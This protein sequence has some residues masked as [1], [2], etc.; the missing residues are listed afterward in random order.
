METLVPI[1]NSIPSELIIVDTGGT[2][3]SIE[4]AREYADLVVPFTWCNDFA[5]ARNTGLEKAKGEWFLY[6]DD[7]EWFEDAGEIIDF[8][9]SGEYLNYNSATYPVRNYQDKEGKRWSES[10]CYRMVKITKNTRFVSPI[11]EILLPTPLPQKFFSCFVHHYGYVF[12]NEEERRKHCY[13]NISLLEAVIK[14]DP[15]NQRLRMQLAQEYG[16]LKDYQ[17]SIELSKESIAIVSKQNQISEAQIIYSGWNMKNVVYT[18]ILLEKREEA[19]QLAVKYSNYRWINTVTKNNLSHVLARLAY[20]L[21]KEDNCFRYTEVYLN[22]YRKLMENETLRLEETLVDQ[23]ESYTEENHFSTLLAAMKAAENMKDRENQQKYLME[24]AKANFFTISR[25]DFSIILSI[26]FDLKD[27]NQQIS[28]MNNFM[29]KE[30]FR[31]QLLNLLEKQPEFMKEEGMLELISVCGDSKEFI[32]YKI[33][34]YYEQ[35]LGVKELVEKYFKEDNN[36]LFS[37]PRVMGIFMEE[38]NLSEYA[39]RTPIEDWLKNISLFVDKAPIESVITVSEI[40]KNQEEAD[41]RILHLQNACYEKLLQAKETEG[42]EFSVLEN[43][44]FQYVNSNLTLFGSLYREE[45]F[46]TELEI[47]LPET[48]RFCN[49]VQAIYEEGL[50]DLA[51]VR[52]IREAVDLCP[53]FAAFCKSYIDRIQQETEAATREFLQLAVMIKKSIRSY[54]AVGQLENARMTLMQLEQLI[55]NDP[56][57]GELKRMV[58]NNG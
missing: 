33:L 55:P 56:E 57:I 42:M 17:K 46:T 48:C 36:I 4:I 50:D 20:Q 35:K 30:A 40:C 13:R 21:G 49:R 31:K 29:E 26:L 34:S 6:L 53:D 44:L 39:A 1:L 23:S 5:K 11:H 8:F 41:L 19:Y 25:N 12:E 28:L 14:E 43:L 52:I 15:S 37:Q 3:G 18:N 58:E 27:K 38:L 10:R 16:V 54:I 45:V 9:K 22:T 24:L 51:K 7:D 32:S 2:D 47:Y